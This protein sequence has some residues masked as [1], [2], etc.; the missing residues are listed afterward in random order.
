MYAIVEIAGQQFKV[1]KDQKIFVHRLEAEAGK[2]VDFD[3]VLL[4][5]TKPITSAKIGVKLLSIPAYPEETPV[6]AYVN[7]KAGIKLP[8][9]PTIAKRTKSVP[10]LIRRIPFIAKG[11]STSPANN[12]RIDAT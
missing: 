4:N 7:K 3:R 5:T 12:I 1:Q 8:T 6:S 2:K 10:V 11:T 9:S